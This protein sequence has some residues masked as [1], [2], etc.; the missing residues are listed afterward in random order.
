MSVPMV[1]VR[2]VR[3]RVLDRLVGMLVRMRFASIPP[4]IMCVLV[5]VIMY[6]QMHVFQ[7]LVIVLM[8]VILTNVQP[9][10]QRH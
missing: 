8:I 10:T 4:K 5:V 3:M 7:S 9:D 1:E 2:I 6:V